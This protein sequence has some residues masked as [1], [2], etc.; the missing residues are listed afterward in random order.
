[1]NTALAMGQPGRHGNVE[2]KYGGP[3]GVVIDVSETG[4]AGTSPMDT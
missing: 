2:Y 4:W 1:M 3:D